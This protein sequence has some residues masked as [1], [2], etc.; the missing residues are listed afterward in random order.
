MYPLGHR[1]CSTKAAGLFPPAVAV[2]SRT[3]DTRVFILS[4]VYC[5]LENNKPYQKYSLILM[6]YAVIAFLG[7]SI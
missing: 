7:K 4:S 3:F 2:A 1:H 5:A 6:S